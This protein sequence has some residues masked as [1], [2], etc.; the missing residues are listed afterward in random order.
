MLPISPT[1]IIPLSKPPIVS[2]PPLSHS[3]TAFRCRAAAAADESPRRSWFNLSAAS[4][5]ASIRI[6]NTSSDNVGY[7][8]ASS[9]NGKVNAKEKWSRNRESYLTDAE[10]AL[11]LPMTYPN[12]SPVS[13]DEIDKRLKCDPEIEVL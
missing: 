5:A 8:A 6:G 10:D 13:P 4:D 9:G 1:S 11:P 2:F 7:G 12:S 3:V